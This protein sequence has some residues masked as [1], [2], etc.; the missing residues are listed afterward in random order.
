MKS[1]QQ[2]LTSTKSFGEFQDLN[3]RPTMRSSAVFPIVHKPGKIISIYTFMGYWLRKRSI[4]MV[5]ALVTLRNE[6]GEK[7]N[8]QSIAVNQTKS[9]EIL[10]TDLIE[11]HHEEF[12][13]SVEIEIFS[14]VDMVFPYPAITFAIKG[15]NGL[16]FVHTC[17]RIYNDFDDLQENTDQKVAETGFDL[18]V[19]EDYAPFFFFFFGPIPIKNKKIKMVY[20]AQTAARVTKKMTISDVEPYGL[21]WVNLDFASDPN[22]SGGSE[23][24]CVKVNHD[25]EG[26]FPRFVAGN[27]FGNFEDISLTH[28][29]YDTSTDKTDDAIWHNPSI[30]E[31]ED[32][33]ASIPFDTDFSK[34]ELAVYPNNAHSKTPVNLKFELYGFDGEFISSKNGN[35]EIGST[36]D[37]LSYIDLLSLFE[38]YLSSVPKGMV[39]LV[40]NGAGST[41]A[42]MKFGL[43][44]C[45]PSGK[46]NLPSNICFNAELPNVKFL[47]KPGT[48]RWCAI[49]DAPTQKI[50]LHNTSFVKEGFKEAQIEVE[51][52]RSK[53]NEKF[54][55]SITIPY[56]G[57]RELLF[58]HSDAITEFLDDSV[59]WVTFSCSS[60]FIYGYY[61]T[62]RNEGV[63]GADHIY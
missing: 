55:W 19:G 61:I 17:G 36:E 32:G 13:G 48:F 58:D 26:F 9:Y 11:D 56:N 41:P 31:F 21:C 30:S 6:S 63:V 14:A 60:P 59:G 23:K 22:L 53:D 44:F 43:N 45:K 49:F 62:N 51:V 27:V 46:K 20:I 38:D 7:K 1:N 3:Y 52:C 54:K 50:Y 40:C 15:T 57:T 18:L 2:H 16:T 5:T 25:F 34:I 33:Y 10:S 29:Y 37:K 8:V 47:K 4:P 28:S 39:K 24:V 35:V 12:Y 42:R